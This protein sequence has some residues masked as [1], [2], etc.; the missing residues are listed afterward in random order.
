MIG[1]DRVR[2][3]PQCKLNVYNF[4]AMPETEIERLIVRHDGRLCARWYRR[5]DGPVLTSDC[6]VGFRAKVKRV[7]KVAGAVLSALVGASPLIAQNPSKPPEPSLTQIQTTNHDE[8]TIV[9]KVTDETGAVIPNADLQLVNELTGET[10]QGK[11]DG[12]GLFNGTGIGPAMY[13]VQAGALGFHLTK[14]EDVY[15]PASASKEVPVVLSLGTAVMGE[16]VTISADLLS[17]DA[18]LPTAISTPVQQL[19]PKKANLWHRML[20][21]VRGRTK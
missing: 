2:F 13:S 20:S 5:A 16:V 4:S 17:T 9:V 15:I 21:A 11:T 8:G 7:S 6:P 3:C 12:S 10:I 14:I 1:D 19:P 18:A